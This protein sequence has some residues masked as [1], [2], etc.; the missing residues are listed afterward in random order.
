MSDTFTYKDGN[1]V[2]GDRHNVG[3]KMP[4]ERH[5]GID[6]PVFALSSSQ[7]GSFGRLRV[8]N[9]STIFDSKQL[10]DNNPLLWDDQEVTGATTT[11]SWTA[12]SATSVLGVANTTA[13]LRMRQT[14]RRFNYQPGKS[15]QVL[16]TGNLQTSGGGAGIDTG[17]GY[18]DDNNGLALVC[19]EGVP[20]WRLRSKVSGSV[21]D[22]DINV[23]G[24]V[25]S[26]TG[27]NGATVQR[28]DPFDGTGPSGITLDPTKSLILAIDFE[29]LSVGTVA[30]HLVY[31][32]AMYPALHIHNAGWL[33]GAYM[34]TP[35]LPCRYWIENDG[36]GAASTMTSICTTVISE[37][38][39][40]PIG[41]PQYESNAASDTACVEVSA[42]TADTI[43]AVVGIKL[44]AASILSGGGAM[45][46]DDVSM[47][48]ETADDF[49]W[50]LVHNP[51]VTGTFTYG[52]I[53]N[54]AM[55]VARGATATVTGGKR[56]K[57]GLSRAEGKVAVSLRSSL[58]LGA[59]I[60]GTPDTVVLCCRPLSANANVHGGMGWTEY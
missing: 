28:I 21:V 34:S 27:A 7:R 10:L 58:S 11:S 40:N 24:A 2:Q 23:A 14:F 46:V 43:Y 4:S 32:R 31:E 9:P 12:N 38:G 1:L 59:N 54:S 8:G 47:I 36:T 49:E 60:A 26:T 39:S 51:T 3:T 37:G 29:W 57:G 20:K 13:G 48:A 25:G 19:V 16:M 17:F 22:M 6:T 18:I 35:N 30:Y 55:Q 50:M 15:Q 41:I 33:A 53:T 56:I 44:K 42:N 5:G 52:D 45:R